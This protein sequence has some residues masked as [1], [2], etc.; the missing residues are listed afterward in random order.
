MVEREHAQRE[1][2][3]VMS[4]LSGSQ[5]AALKGLDAQEQHLAL[6]VRRDAC[7][8]GKKGER[9]EGAHIWDALIVKNVL[10]G[11]HRPLLDWGYERE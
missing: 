9:A 2:R 4:R 1:R 10:R 6:E 5:Q 3:S 8:A 7:H 11:V